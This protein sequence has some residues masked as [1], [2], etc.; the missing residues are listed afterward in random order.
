MSATTKAR[1]QAL[2][3]VARLM[4][5][6]D[7]HEQHTITVDELRVA[8]EGVDVEGL[9]EPRPCVVSNCAGAFDLSQMRMHTCLPR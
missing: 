8:L 3:R 6:A 2:A 4:R 5:A 1:S 9:A 7:R